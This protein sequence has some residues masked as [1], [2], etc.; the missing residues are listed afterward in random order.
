MLNRSCIEK[1]GK[2]ATQPW[3]QRDNPQERPDE[4]KKQ[5]MSYSVREDIQLAATRV[6][7]FPFTFS[8][9]A[10]LDEYIL[11]VEGKCVT[12]GV[13][14][15]AEPSK[16][17]EHQSIK[18]IRNLGYGNRRAKAGERGESTEKEK[19]EK[20]SLSSHPHYVN[21]HLAKSHHCPCSHPRVNRVSNPNP[22]ITQRQPTGDRE[23]RK[24]TP[25]LTESAV[26]SQEELSTHLNQELHRPIHTRL[27]KGDEDKEERGE[28]MR[29]EQ[30]ES[31][32][33][34]VKGIGGDVQNRG[35]HPDD[36]IAGPQSS[37]DLSM[38][39]INGP[40]LVLIS[41]PGRHR[42]DKSTKV[43]SPLSNKW[44][45]ITT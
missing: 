2:R 22:S 6:M 5:C 1:A 35:I 32:A 24:K 3:T 10:N 21:E 29:D 14:E 45:W 19:D 30:K 41:H 25:S 39:W 28:G 18:S 38:K 43:H 15:R 37:Q 34:K 31:D 36:Y 13:Q 33:Q 16:F 42:G 23:G 8:P 20:K 9:P 12:H 40:K 44:K 17:Y 27:R 26:R 7:T 4:K 11:V